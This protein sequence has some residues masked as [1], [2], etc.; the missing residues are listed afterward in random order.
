MVEPARAGA[1][2]M[3]G[4]VW[5]QRSSEVLDTM[6][7]RWSLAGGTVRVTPDASGLS[8]TAQPPSSITMPAGAGEAAAITCDVGGF[9][10]VS[11]GARLWRL[12]P[13]AGVAGGWLAVATGLPAGPITSLRQHPSGYAAVAVGLRWPSQPAP[14]LRLPREAFSLGI[15]IMAERA[16]RN[17]GAVG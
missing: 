11:D 12:D 16:R 8:T 14:S 7:N 6:G 15:R 9:V 17:G 5:G 4:T 3:S 1:A 13:R 10:W 2:L